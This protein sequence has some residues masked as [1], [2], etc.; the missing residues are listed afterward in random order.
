[1][2]LIEFAFLD[3]IAR[4]LW[5]EEESN[6][7]DRW[8]NE[9]QG[10]RD[11]VAVSPSNLGRKVVNDCSNQSTNAGKNVECRN[12]SSS[13]ASRD[14]FLDVYLTKGLGESASH[15]IAL[16]LSYHIETIGNTNQK[17]AGIDPSKV[18]GSHHDAI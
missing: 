5:D 7:D 2:C 13:I 17:S 6:R 3:K 14:D 11:Q 16:K 10:Q 8:N 18:R 12:G 4:R 15:L 1:M 9:D